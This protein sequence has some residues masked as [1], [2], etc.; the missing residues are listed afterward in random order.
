MVKS[1]R[2]QISF[3]GERTIFLTNAAGKTEYSHAKG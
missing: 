1:M 2:M 3:N